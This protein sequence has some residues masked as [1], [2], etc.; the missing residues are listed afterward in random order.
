[1]SQRFGSYIASKRKETWK[2]IQNMQSTAYSLVVFTATMVVMFWASVFLYTSFYFTYMPDESV[3]W[4]VHFQYRSCHDKPGI[5]SNPF[6]VISVTDPTRGSLLARGQKYRVV[7][8]IDM[9]ESPTNQKIGM[10]LINMNMKSH[11]GEVLREASRSSMLRYKSSLLQTLSTI[12]FA[13]LLLY[14]IH[15][16]KQMVTVELFSQYEEDPVSSQTLM[17][18]SHPLQPMLFVCLFIN[19]QTF[20][21]FKI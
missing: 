13:P 17:W 5:C 2:Y 19:V 11:T 9:P 21:L 3:M 18:H 20:L 8:D 12:T 10:F 6:A 1:M 4:P 16:E 15:E 7:V 14:G